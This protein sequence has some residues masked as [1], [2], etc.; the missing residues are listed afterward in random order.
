VHYGYY[1][2]FT[3]HKGPLRARSSPF[4]GSITDK[5]F[6]IHEGL[7]QARSSPPMWSTTGKEFAIHG[8]ALYTGKEFLG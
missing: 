7:L 3:I 6:S 4:T 8:E 1:K 5:E 2:D